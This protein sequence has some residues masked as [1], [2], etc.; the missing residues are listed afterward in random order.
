[1]YILKLLPLSAVLV[2]LVAGSCYSK[3]PPAPSTLRNCGF[4]VVELFTS[5]GCSSCPAAEAVLTQLQN[6]HRQNVIVMEYHVDYWNYLG[7]QDIFSSKQFTERQ[8]HYAGLFRL[9]SAYTPQAIVNGKYELVG[10]DKEKLYRLVDDVMKVNTT[11]SIQISAK[12]KNDH[13]VVNYHVTGAIGQLL[14]ILVVQNNAV[15][16]VKKGE[17]S[18]RKLQHI[19]VARILK[20]IPLSGDSGSINLPTLAGTDVRECTIVAYTQNKDSWEITGA[21]TVPLQ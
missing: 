16:N 8:Q 11:A 15:S 1:M 10:S 5:E 19:N 13:I 2:C 9:S 12:L 18:G 20:T 14:N 4:A 6:E 21:E 17:N 7:W 3:R